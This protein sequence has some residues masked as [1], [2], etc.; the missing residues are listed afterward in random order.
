MRVS[1]TT[2]LPC[3]PDIAWSVLT[4][5]EAQAR[6][7]RDADGVQVVSP[8]RTGVGVRLAV[9]TRLFGMPAFT[10]PLEVTT[11]DPPRSLTIRHGGPVRGTGTWTLRPAED[12][13]TTSFTWVEDVRL[14]VPFV[15]RALAALYGPVLVILMGRG[16][17][18][19]R[20]R[21]AAD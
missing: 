4:D 7:M 10:E 8:H 19:L 13:G 17:M 16:Q 3:A 6:W 12:P 20:R 2:V 5:W 14:A 18:D 15:G 11:W 9:K 1:R 21:V